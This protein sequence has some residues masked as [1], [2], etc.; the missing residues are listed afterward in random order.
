[1]S[2]KNFEELEVWKRS[3][4]IAVDIYAALDSSKDFGLKD[5]MQRSAVSI[6]SNIA[7]GS[8]RASTPEYIR[9]LRIA[10][11]SC[12][13]LRTQ[14]YIS[15]KIRLTTDQAP[16]QQAKELIQETKEISAML[17][18]LITSLQHTTK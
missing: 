12:A 11:S 10:K 9:F 13:E 6:A 17:Q 3:C 5:Q 15:Q 16:L 4:Q 14:I 8:E 2:V 7:E 18:G 1:M